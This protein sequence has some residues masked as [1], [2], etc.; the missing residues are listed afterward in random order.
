[1]IYPKLHSQLVEEQG[2]YSDT[3]PGELW[4]FAGKTGLVG[5]GVAQTG[6]QFAK[7]IKKT[8]TQLFGSE[9]WAVSQSGHEVKPF[10]QRKSDQVLRCCWNA[11]LTMNWIVLEPAPSFGLHVDMPRR[12]SFPLDFSSIQS[13]RQV[14]LFL[15]FEVFALQF[16]L[17]IVIYPPTHPLPPELINH[18]GGWNL[19]HF[20]YLENRYL[21]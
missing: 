16:R 9:V 1:M 17:M 6:I 12:I 4:Y 10:P 18:L 15:Q 8:H 14:E 21:K 20:K 3:I 11:G 5:K 19:T 7:P 2:L 13:G